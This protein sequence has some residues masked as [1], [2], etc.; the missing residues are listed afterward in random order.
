[1]VLHNRSEEN[2][3]HLQQ[4]LDCLGKLQ[5]II[6]LDKESFSRVGLSRNRVLENIR[7]NIFWV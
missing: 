3:N 4:L 2:H 6:R 5:H 1:M 7:V